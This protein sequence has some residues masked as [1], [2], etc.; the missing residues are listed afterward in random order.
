MAVGPH[1]HIDQMLAKKYQS[2]KVNNT[3]DLERLCISSERY[4]ELQKDIATVQRT[5]VMVG[6]KFKN[7]KSTK[8]AGAA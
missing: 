5:L 2:E 6:N 7:I 4:W 1:D 8:S 3:E